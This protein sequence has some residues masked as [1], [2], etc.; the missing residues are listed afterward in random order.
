MDASI[1]LLIVEDSEEDA[2]LVLRLLRQSGYE[3]DS[4]RVDSAGSLAQALNKKWDIVIA[5]HS[6]PH[7]SWN[8]ALK[9]VRVLF[10]P[11][12]AMSLSSSGDCRRGERA[13]RPG[14]SSS[15]ASPWP[16]TLRPG[17]EAAIGR[18]AD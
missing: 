12:R 17:V 9:M 11:A 1:R 18:V 3:I 15:E 16:M 8:E 2:A 13:G 5:D 7:F 10:Q 6:M 4:E 14:A